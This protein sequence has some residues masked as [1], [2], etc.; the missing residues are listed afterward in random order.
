MRDDPEAAMQGYAI[1]PAR[2]EHLPL[3]G[4]IET[5]AAGLFPPGSIPDA[6]RSDCLPIALLE[7]G[8][9]KGRLWVALTAE[10][11]PV[12]YALLRILD[13]IALLAQIDVL[14]AHGRRGIGRELVAQAALAARKEGFS[15]LWLTT[16]THVPWN[17][18]F[19]ARIGFAAE[20]EDSLPPVIRRILQTERAAGFSNRT[21][22]RLRL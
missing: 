14:P 21:A 20:P 8:R 13:R 2:P 18:P 1:Q 6:A 19:Y 22:M 12:G 16:F 11:I 5:E 7:E 9:E 3:L 10:E 4:K 17:A 15:S